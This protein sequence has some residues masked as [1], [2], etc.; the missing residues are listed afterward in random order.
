MTVSALLIVLVCLSTYRFTRLIVRDL[1]P[2]MEV[3]RE[4]V[5]RKCGVSHWLS[6]LVTCYW[7]VSLYVGAVIVVLAWWFYGLPY[8]LLVWPVSSAVTGLISQREKIGLAEA[9]GR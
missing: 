9:L 4:W 6:Y 3:F 7:C 1:F 2:P 5:L 8:P